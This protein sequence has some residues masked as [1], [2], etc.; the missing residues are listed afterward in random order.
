VTN[1]AADNNECWRGAVNHA[2]TVDILQVNL[3]GETEFW[4]TDP[5]TDDQFFLNT[6]T[7]RNVFRYV[8]RII[9]D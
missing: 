5:N 7:T 9:I 3:S 2:V 1:Y 8:V 4:R 6:D